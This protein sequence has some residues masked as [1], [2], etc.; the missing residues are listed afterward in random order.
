MQSGS[1]KERAMNVIAEI[2][3]AKDLSEAL[4]CVVR[5]FAADTGVASAGR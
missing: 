4:G 2:Q 1:A 3:A 5:G